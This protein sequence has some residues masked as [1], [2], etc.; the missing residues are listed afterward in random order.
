MANRPCNLPDS[1][2]SSKK[3]NDWLLARNT[4]EILESNYH[5]LRRLR[6]TKWGRCKAKDRRDAPIGSRL[7]HTYLG[8]YTSID[9]QRGI[10]PKCRTLTMYSS[11]RSPIRLG[12]LS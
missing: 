2:C 4:S 5:D 3:E 12:G 6:R 1:A 10:D 11:E 9:S 8:G 7:T